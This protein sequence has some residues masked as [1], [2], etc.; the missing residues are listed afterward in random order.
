M[1]DLIR[2]SL[3]SAYHE[4]LPLEKKAGRR[5][6][7]AV[8]V[9]GPICES[10]D[11]FAKDRRLAEPK[12]GECVVVRST[13]AFGFVMSSNYNARPRAAEVLVEGKRWEVVRRRET[14]ADLVR[15][16]S[17]PDFVRRGRAETPRRR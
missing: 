4:I 7:P 11:F 15:G 17:V 13:G 1:N 2:P 3:Y 14:Y 10:S 5:V 6:L 12:A 16:E 9:V 8:D